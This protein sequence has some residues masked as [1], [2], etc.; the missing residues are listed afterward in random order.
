MSR[1]DA[2]YIF[3]LISPPATGAEEEGPKRDRPVFPNTGRLE[4]LERSLSSRQ[5]VTSL[6]L[7][8]PG[9]T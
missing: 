8:L 5:G 4:R 9:G 7:G 1:T 6:L 3:E 2:R